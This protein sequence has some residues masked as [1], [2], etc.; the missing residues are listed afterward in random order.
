MNSD[1]IGGICKK[2]LLIVLTLQLASCGTIY[3]YT[4]QK[5]RQDYREG[6]SLYKKGKYA[7]AMD[8]FQEVISIDPD[9]RGAKRY[10]IITQ[11]AME[12]S[13]RSHYQKALQYRS[14][15]NLERA[16]DEFLIVMKK[17]PDYRDT[18]S[19][20]DSIR[21][22]P[23]IQRVFEKKFK[24]AERYYNRKRYKSAY[25]HCLRAE[26]YKPDSVELA[27]LERN[28]ESALRDQSGRYLR[29]GEELY[30]QKRY[31]AAQRY[32]KKA[33]RVNPWDKDARNL[34]NQCNSKIAVAEMYDR[35]RKKYGKRD[36][37]AAYELFQIIDR[38]EPGFRD[39]KSYIER[40][41]KL[42]E[43]SKWKYYNT[44]IA[45]YDKEQFKEA[46]AEWNKVLKIDPDHKKAREYKERAL[47][48][49]AIKRSLED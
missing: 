41:K 36:Y 31:K 14:A 7:D 30:S 22:S 29:K 9:H 25:I 42:L 32:L 23:S 15:G 3:R 39:T 33:L 13:S 16:L 1:T 35:A 10:I 18:K 11:E 40:T 2:L 44:G 37:F 24:L 4:K 34:L 38:K 20:V 12:K 17:D 21:S 19:Q 46:I 26:K 5:M 28:I 48:K 27:L 49:L 43:K 47:A 45:Y 6:I 8:K